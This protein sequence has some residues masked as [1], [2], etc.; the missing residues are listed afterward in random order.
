MV[1]RRLLLCLAKK[2]RS[3]CGSF[4]RKWSTNVKY[5]QMNYVTDFIN[6][7][8]MSAGDDST[9]FPA[10]ER[11]RHEAK[12]CSCSWSRP[13]G[14]CRCVR[15]GTP[16]LDGKTS[17]RLVRQAALVGRRQFHSVRRHQRT[18]DVSSCD[19]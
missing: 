1:A 13:V 14:N 4:L 11:F 2:C 12:I 15:P 19:L 6:S 5:R 8:M 9:D 10:F 7:Y 3:C 16:A 17:E 18:R